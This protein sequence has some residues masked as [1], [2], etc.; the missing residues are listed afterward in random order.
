MQSAEKSVIPEFLDQME[1]LGVRH[2]FKGYH[3]KVV[4]LVSGSE[5]LFYGIK[6]SSGNQTARLK[7]IPGVTTWVYDEFE[8]HPEERSFDTVDNS[9]RTK[10]LP[11]RVILVSNALHKDSWQYRRFLGPIYEYG[12]TALGEP[13]V[14]AQSRSFPNRKKILKDHHTEIIHTTFYDNIKNL[15]ESFLKNVYDSMGSRKFDIQF[16]GMHYDITDGALFKYDMFKNEEKV[17]LKKM[18]KIV[19]AVDPA[20]SQEAD[21]DLTGIVVVAKSKDDLYYVL[22]DYSGTYSPLEWAQVSCRV[23]RQFQADEIV[24]ES[25]NGG[26]LVESNIRN[27]A[28]GEFAVNKVRA[29]RGKFLR[30]EPIKNLYEQGKVFHVGNLYKLEQEMTTWSPELSKKSPDRLDALVWGMTRLSRKKKIFII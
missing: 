16:L 8:E 5:I 20:V 24:A 30:A 7:S 29:T 28:F 3:R 17:D 4:N 9:I 22:G 23:A 13:K 1:R 12:V 11:N 26:D 15:S 6:G 27:Y 14:I 21:S 19:V 2:L 25:N 10:E 18:K